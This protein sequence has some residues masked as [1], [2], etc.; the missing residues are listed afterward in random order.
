MTLTVKCYC[1]RLFDFLIILLFLGILPQSIADDQRSATVSKNAPNA[2]T[3]AFSDLPQKTQNWTRYLSVSTDDSSVFKQVDSVAGDASS[4]WVLIDGYEVRQLPYSFPQENRPGYI[5][6][7]GTNNPDAECKQ[8]QPQFSGTAGFIGGSGAQNNDYAWNV[9]TNEFHTIYKTTFVPSVN[10]GGFERYPY[11]PDFYVY[12]APGKSLS[13]AFNSALHAT[14][15]SSWKVD[16]VPNDYMVQPYSNYLATWFGFYPGN[17]FD[18]AYVNQNPD[19]SLLRTAFRTI[20]GNDSAFNAVFSYGFFKNPDQGLTTRFVFI[21][22]ADQARNA[23]QYTMHLEADCMKSPQPK[24][25]NYTVSSHNCTD[26]C[27]SA[28]QAAG[29][30]VPNMK[31]KIGMVYGNNQVFEYSFSLTSCP[32]ALADYLDSLSF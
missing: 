31:K 30:D 12:Y 29:I 21:I 25:V 9:I 23:I 3:N 22:D 5:H 15:H 24:N 26:A 28:M 19:Y 18:D 7:R 4:S 32:A 14:G 8:Y 20:T 10:R 27:I 11:E 1:N 13:E 2:T 16:C 17:P 6:Y